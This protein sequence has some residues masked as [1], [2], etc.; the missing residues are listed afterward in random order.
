M[1]RLTTNKKASEMGMYE[2]AHNGCYVGADGSARHRDYSSDVDCREM[3]KKMMVN[4]GL[5]ESD[6]WDDVSNEV[7]DDEMMENLMYGIN[8]MQ[9]LI[10]LFY[11]NMWAMAD[12]REKLKYFEDLEEQGLLV[13]LPCKIGDTVYQIPS[14]VNY[15]LNVLHGY[16]ANNRV[17]HQKV[18]KIVLDGEYW[19]LECDKDREYGT[20]R[21][22]L[23]RSFGETWFLTKEEAEKAL[24]EMESA[25]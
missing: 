24:K 9:G 1:R 14:K 7:F 22:C 4:F 23:D 5:V 17:Y 2:L 13:K 25:E 21:I 18:S 11:R 8:D 19:Y 6:Y 3:I 12:L 15:D 10:A 16:D 20:G